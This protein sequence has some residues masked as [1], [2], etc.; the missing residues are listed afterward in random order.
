MCAAD[1]GV[2]FGGQLDESF[3]GEIG[4]Q[5]IQTYETSVSQ[6]FSWLHYTPNSR[7]YWRC[8]VI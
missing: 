6:F 4:D 2:F 1:H 5:E 8:C 7:V 3:C